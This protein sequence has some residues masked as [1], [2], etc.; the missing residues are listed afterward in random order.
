MSRAYRELCPTA[1]TGINRF[2]DP[3]DQIRQAVFDA[4]I[5]DMLIDDGSGSPRI[6]LSQVIEEAPSEHRSDTAFLYA[7]DIE[8]RLS[9]CPTLLLAVHEDS[10]DCEGDDAKA[11]SSER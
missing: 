4:G 9:V 10:A 3:G 2:H 8:G 7:C 6:F 5:F 1:Q 11:S